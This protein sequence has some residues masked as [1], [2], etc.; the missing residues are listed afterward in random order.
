[1]TTNYIKVVCDRCG[2]SVEMENKPL[3]WFPSDWQHMILGQ[4]GAELDMCNNCNENLLH[5][6]EVDGA[7]G[8]K[9]ALINARPIT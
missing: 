2:N 3:E 4:T 9:E 8:M 6:M 5:F 7:S 1:M